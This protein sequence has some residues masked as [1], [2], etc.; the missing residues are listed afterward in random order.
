MQ[1]QHIIQEHHEKIWNSVRITKMKHRDTKWASAVGMCQKICSKKDCHKP[2]I[3][4]KCNICSVQLL[5]GVRLFVT[6]WTS[7][8]QASLS[9]TNSRSLLKLICIELVMLSNLLHPPSSPF[10]PAFNLSQHLGLFKWVHPNPCV[11][12][13]SKLDLS[14]IYFIIVNSNKNSKRFLFDLYINYVNYGWPS[15]P[16]KTS[17]LKKKNSH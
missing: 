8:R 17:S 13:A 7:A 12:I 1:Q 5:S 3:C 14:K 9:I 6:P 15:Y 16:L 11:Y 4:R 10:P 2:F